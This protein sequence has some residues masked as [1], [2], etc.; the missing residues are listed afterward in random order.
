M[1]LAIQTKPADAY[2]DR[3]LPMRH[4]HYTCGGCGAADNDHPA[5]PG[6][7]QRLGPWPCE[8]YDWERA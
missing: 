6:V 2:P 3:D 7:G 1:S 8:G 5:Q 4:G